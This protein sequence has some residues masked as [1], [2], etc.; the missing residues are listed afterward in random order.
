M[1]LLKRIILHI[2]REEKPHCKN[3]NPLAKIGSNVKITSPDS[4]FM[5][6]YT[7]INGDAVIMN[8]PGGEFIIKKNTR[9]AVG[10]LAICGNHI[11]VVGMLHR[12]VTE[13]MKKKLDVEG[14]YSKPIVIEEDVWVGAN[15][16]IT[17][18]VTIH[19]GAVVGAGSVVRRDIPPYGIVIGN[20]SK[21]V[22]FKFTPDEIL[23]HEKKLYK[24]EERLPEDLLRSNYKELYLDKKDIIKEFKNLS[25]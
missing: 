5:E 21:L 8:G 11:P 3:V 14:R 20:P 16:T 25:L 23:E 15:V 1:N 13:E 7:S 24:K 17:Q 9:I 4:L 10:L 22:G 18:G 12:E 19:R 6:E 2:I